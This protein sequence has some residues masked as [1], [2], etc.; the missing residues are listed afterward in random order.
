MNSKDAR[1]DADAAAATLLLLY[2]ALGV[3][4]VV[5]TL[6]DDVLLVACQNRGDV[7]PLCQRVIEE[8]QI[9][10]DRTIN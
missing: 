6:D 9:P 8:H 3:A 2:E 7:V 5:M 10:G 4:A 1:A